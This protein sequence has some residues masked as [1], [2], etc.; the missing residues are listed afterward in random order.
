MRQPRRDADAIALAGLIAISIALSI[1]TIRHRPDSTVNAAYLFQDEGLNLLVA[2]VVNRG[3]VLYRDLA[4][5]YGPLPAYLHAAI[6]RAFGDTPLVYLSY[7]IATSSMTVALAFVLLRR[8]ADTGVATFVTAVGIVTTIII[9]GSLI[10][11]QTTAAYVPV[12]RAA[13]LAA[14]LC[15]R[16][17]DRRSPSRSIALGTTLGLWQAVRFGGA[18]VAG[19]SIVI[20]DALCLASAGLS[21]RHVGRWIRSSAIIAAAFVV[22]ELLWIVVAFAVLPRGIAQ[23]AIWPAYVLE[24]Y[25]EWV[26]SAIRWLPWGGWRLF[27][28]QYLVPFSGGLLGLLGVLRSARQS[29]DDQD[30]RA[31][32][33]PLIFFIVGCFIYFKQV[34]HFRQFMWTLVPASAWWLQRNGWRWRIATAILWAPGFLIVVRSSLIGAA[35]STATPI[36]L[37]TGGT[38]VVDQRQAERIDF[39]ARFVESDARRQPV[40]FL[41]SGAGW[42]D[43]FD[44]PRA[45][46]HAW[47][48]GFDIIRP[49]E[50]DA[51]V[52]ALD[53]TAA[54]IECAKDTRPLTSPLPDLPFSDAVKAVLVPRLSPWTSGAGCRTFRV[55]R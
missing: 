33:L 44:V 10:G 12:E 32:F 48:A 55:S 30:D 39:L 4:Y 14:A 21:R 38:I 24:A 54:V 25:G 15:W 13:L 2:G 17:P 9:P 53:R 49:Y 37:P 40:I 31:L 1:A 29:T 26:S 7:L 11:G 47:F 46:R 19:G 3:G 16:A 41:D 20:L 36:A 35:A 5:P 6:A 27:V 22:I 45:T 52:S 34:H 43:A 23:D 42:Y 50:Q 51:F 8:A 28:V 18:F